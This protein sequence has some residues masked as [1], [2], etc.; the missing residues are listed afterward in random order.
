[1]QSNESN[2]KQ[3]PQSLR[4]C[5]ALSTGRYD[6]DKPVFNEMIAY[7]NMPLTLFLFFFVVE[8]SMPLMLNFIFF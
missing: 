5:L 2:P 7:M 1:M 3:A 6:M 4:G 8:I